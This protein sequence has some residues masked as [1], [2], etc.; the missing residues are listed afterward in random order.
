MSVNALPSYLLVIF[1]SIFGSGASVKKSPD[2]CISKRLLPQDIGKTL[3]SQLSSTD[4]LILPRNYSQFPVA[5]DRWT[6]YE[7]PSAGA[8]VIAYTISDVITTVGLTDQ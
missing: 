8:V 3:G 4:A 6:Q 1:L 2:F 5:V 7:S